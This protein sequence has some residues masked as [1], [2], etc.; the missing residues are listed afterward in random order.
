ML[1]CGMYDLLYA[2][3][4][5]FIFTVLLELM[6]LVT[7]V[8]ILYFNDVI[9]WLLFVFTSAINTYLIVWKVDIFDLTI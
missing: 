2:C 4:I 1:N 7:T 8:S 9:M 5:T 3:D 6:I